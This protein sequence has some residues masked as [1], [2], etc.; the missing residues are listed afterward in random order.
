MQDLLAL[1][2]AHLRAAVVE[3]LG[4]EHAGAD[5]AV[6]PSE[7]RFGDFQ[8]NLALGLAKSLR[9]Q[10]RELA[11][12]LTVALQARD[13]GRDFEAIS[14]AGPGFI[15][16]QLTKTRIATLA[17]E[18][19]GDPRL[20]VPSPTQPL[21]VVIDYPSPNL[22]KE[23]HVGH[24]RSTIIGDALARVLRFA[25]HTILP[26]NHLGDWGTQFGML[27]EHLLDSG[28]DR[29][30]DHSISDLNLLYQQ[31]KA[32]FDA[33]ENFKE[34]ARARVVTLQSGDAESLSLWRQLITESCAHMKET[35]AR[36]GVD[37]RDENVR[38]ESFFN[39]QLPDVVTDLQKLGLLV[40]SEGAEV[41]YCDG[42]SGKTG[43]PLPLIVR[44]SDGGFGYAATDLAAARFRI[45]TLGADRVIYVVDARQSDHFAM[46]FTALRQA[47]WVPPHV[48]LEHVAFGTILGEDRRPFKTREGGVVKLS[49]LIDEAVERAKAALVARERELPAAELEHIANA[50]GV[51]AIKYAD[52]ANDRIKDYVFNY[53]RMLAMDGNTA[54]Y[55]QYAYVRVRSILRRGEGSAET[56]TNSTA[57]NVPSELL[58]GETVERE[59]TLML[60]QFP[61]TVAQVA[62][63]LEPHRLCTYLHEIAATVH[64]FHETCPVL[65]AE[66]EALKQSRLAL[67]DLAGRVLAQGMEL[68]GVAVVERM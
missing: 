67:S 41:V 21:R 63:S 49:S 7:P 12:A 3:V 13:S 4:P 52:L 11:Q 68:L 24:L 66:T 62:S 37:L 15:N 20:G 32:R 45:G 8:S 9:R 6:R 44:K 19:L 57:R 22:A 36:L 34:R 28:W 1:V 29:T 50:V 42:F 10:P 38:G 16:L 59:L 25:G 39:D 56:A 5:P 51:S 40:H 33:D 65:K 47:G 18:Q 17:L 23:M 2:E 31:A 35:C 48:Q 64:R 14:V 53:E 43:A 58:L 27:L 60:L 26:Q 30:A 55:L 61:R 54:P 46:V